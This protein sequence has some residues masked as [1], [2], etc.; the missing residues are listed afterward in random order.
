M[1]VKSIAHT[2]RRDRG[3]TLIE[4]LLMIA[5]LGIIV[6]LLA[7]IERFLFD[8]LRK[9]QVSHTAC[10][11]LA[12]ST[13]M[14]AADTRGAESYSRSRMGSLRLFMQDGSEVVWTATD[15]GAERR[16]LSAGRD[17]LL[18]RFR[19]IRSLS[20]ATS[21]TGLITATLV[22]SSGDTRS[23]TRRLRRAGEG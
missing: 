21:E 23:F 1:N 18:R 6:V 17:P 16:V 10:M 20:V 11:D 3:S 15:E 19:G 9:A 5:V 12:Y 7:P 8:T 22:A 14:L 2:C 13:A 4:M